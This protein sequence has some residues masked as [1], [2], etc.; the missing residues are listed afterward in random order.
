MLNYYNVLEDI[1]DIFRENYMQKSN[2]NKIIIK[3]PKTI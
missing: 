3:T 2:Y 1:V